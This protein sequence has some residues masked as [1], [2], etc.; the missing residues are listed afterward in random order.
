MI[1]KKISKQQQKHEELVEAVKFGFVLVGALAA[2][3]ISFCV[4]V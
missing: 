3:I 2:D 4:I 1:P